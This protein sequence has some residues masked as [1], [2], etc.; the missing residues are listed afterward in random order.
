M[1]NLL[2]PL[3]ISSPLVL[4][5]S[6]MQACYSVIEL[7]FRNLPKIR[8]CACAVISV[9]SF[10]ARAVHGEFLKFSKICYFRSAAIV[11]MRLVI[12]LL[13]RTESLTALCTFLANV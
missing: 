10:T 13:L 9:D 8:S 4:A 2:I 12:A 1:K 6:K 11:R 5:S 7:S 3:K